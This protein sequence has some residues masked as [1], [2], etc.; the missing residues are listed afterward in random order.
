MPPVRLSMAQT[1]ESSESACEGLPWFIRHAQPW[2]WRGGCHGWRRA[3][4]LSRQRARTLGWRLG[5]GQAAGAAGQDDARV[6]A[7][8]DQEDTAQR[9]THRAVPLHTATGQLLRAGRTKEEK[10]ERGE[11]T[12]DEGVRRPALQ[13]HGRH[14]GPG[15]GRQAPGDPRV[16]QRPMQAA[17]EAPPL[18]LRGCSFRQLSPQKPQSARLSSLIACRCWVQVQRGILTAF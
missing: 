18:P 7:E 12:H 1:S 11:K 6:P 3:P 16:P 13:A 17:E 5:A 14:A 15:P 10:S 4:G 8:V 9:H 2:C